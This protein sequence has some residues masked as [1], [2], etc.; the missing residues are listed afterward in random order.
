VCSQTSPV[1][2]AAHLRLQQF[3]EPGQRVGAAVA[4][5]AVVEAQQA[6]AVARA[7]LQGAVRSV[8]MGSI[9]K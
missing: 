4:V 3:V 8:R 7:A 2:V 6:E 9:R 1:G 5:V